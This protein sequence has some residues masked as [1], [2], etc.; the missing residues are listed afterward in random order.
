MGDSQ[1]R[2]KRAGAAYPRN[3]SARLTK[4][5]GS[6]RFMRRALVMVLLLF[7]PVVNAYVAPEPPSPI[8]QGQGELLLE[9]PAGVWTYEEWSRVS[10]EGLTPLRVLSPTYLL[11]WGD[12]ALVPD[13]WTLHE[14]P[15][16]PWKQGVGG[17]L[18]F[19][20][21][22]VRILLEPRLPDVGFDQVR[23]NFATYGIDIG[24]HHSTSALAQVH[25]I[26]WP[27]GLEIDL[28]L[29]IDG[30]LW[31][32][33]VLETV[34]RNEISA[35]FL[36]HGAPNEHPAW[37]LGINGEGVVVGVADSGLDADHACFR[38]A[39]S[40]Q[41]LGNGGENGT[42]L[43]GEP[44]ED[45][46][47][48][49]LL[50]T[51]IDGGDT[52]GHADYRHG[53]HVAGTL[54]CFNVEDE[55]TGAYPTNGSSLSHASSLVFQD[56]VS[57]EGWVAPDVD[58]LL[59]E[60]GM[61]GGVI[62]S[63][64]WGDDTTAYTARTSD[65]DAWALAMPW[66]LAFI[67]PGNTGGSLLEPANGRNVAA[68]G[69]SMKSVDAQRWSSSS[70]GPTEADTMGIFALAI[71]TSVQSAKAD[72]LPNS[73]N[74]DLRTSTGTSMATPAA[75]GTAA[76]IQQMVELG[77]LSGKELRS[78]I[79]MESQVPE[80]GDASLHNSTIGVGSGFTPSGPMLRALL[81]L[82]T[83]PLPEGERN[84]GDGGH[85]LQNSYD[86][87]GQLNLSQL[88]DFT[89]L[90]DELSQGHASPADDVWIH[91]SF[92]LTNSTPQS[93][94][95]SRQGS[96]EPL[97][98]LIAHPWN[99]TG[100]AGPFLRTGDVW[101]QRFTL[102]ADVPLE[103]RMAHNA[104]PEPTAVDDFQLI[105]R[106][107]DGRIALASESNN[108]GG[109][110]LYYDDVDFDNTSQFQ[111]TNETTHGLR[112][113]LGDLEGVTWVEIEVRARFVAPG[114]LPEG[115]GLD[116]A[117]SGFALAVK[118][119]QRDTEDWSD[120][121]GDGVANLEDE[122]PN[123]NALGWD[124]N[125]DGCLD[126]N[127]GDGVTE[128]LDLC[129]GVDASQFDFDNDGCID[130][131]DG[132]G[133]LDN[134]DECSTPEPNASWPVDQLGCRPI[135]IRPAITIIQTPENDSLWRGNLT[136]KWSI[137]DPDGD[138]FVTGARIVVVDNRS[139][140]GAYMIAGC[141]FES[142]DSDAFECTWSS[143]EA[144]PIWSVEDSSLRLDVFVESKN[145]SPEADNARV[146]IQSDQLF[147]AVYDSPFVEDPLAD[148]TERDKGIGSQ[149]RALFWG[150][151][152]ILAAC[153]FVYRIGL[154]NLN[155]NFVDHLEDPFVKTEVDQTLLASGE[156]E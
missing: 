35:S 134:L 132:D 101:T 79:S 68:I 118:G 145:S 72:N 30:V 138:V 150:L 65:F 39:T 86:G 136:A 6:T 57:D 94:L 15:L 25:D 97:E 126:D 37:E 16:A 117:R 9:H 93:W 19:A 111:A 139:E 151:A 5:E 81:A 34:A 50:N 155:R 48:V 73:Y 120:G 3:S 83:T 38:N 95:A 53:T 8:E 71:G 127:D 142:N 44:G 156:N 74:G 113:D 29:A 129:P 90:H 140:E 87:W 42:E 13:D 76:L 45:H 58:R 52:Q 12:S 104:A 62:H 14:S 32:E 153:V 75:A 18:P 2:L 84:G 123:Q 147:R 85:E 55:R 69:A 141:E 41:S 108:D 36:Q 99:G 24:G 103:V 10:D 27:A 33:P 122:C 131:S 92:R 59:V 149:P 22:D 116:G 110:T 119:V 114:N 67:A 11:A 63:N 49:L 109:A 60:A 96:E 133:V 100:A 144:L 47:K 154:K 121:D 88:V 7:L 98:N 105:V 128:N 137:E 80:W 78:N 107:S 43:V 40:V 125:S 112:L 130:D 91:D 135:D 64:S 143:A 106:L 56:I 4:L 66:S 1:T 89:A 46:R 51:T 146:V 77:W 102:E 54:A 20:G 31:V 17:E 70:I 28:L 26:Q 23:A 21:Q 152:G 148:K 61:Q 124:E 82:A 115:V